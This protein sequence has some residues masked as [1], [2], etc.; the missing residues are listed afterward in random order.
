MEK[1]RYEKPLK[2]SYIIYWGGL[3]FTHS[4]VFFKTHEIYV[5]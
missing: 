2:K 1:I 4:V 3:T 5:K